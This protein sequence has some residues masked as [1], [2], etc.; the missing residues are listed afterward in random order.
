MK[1]IIVSAIVLMLFAGVAGTIQAIQA[2]SNGLFNKLYQPTHPVLTKKDIYHHAGIKTEL[3]SPTLQ[4]KTVSK[5]TRE[6]LLHPDGKNIQ[7]L[8]VLNKKSSKIKATE[9]INPENYH[10]V[11]NTPTPIKVVKPK[12]FK[13]EM[14]SRGAID[15]EYI[16]E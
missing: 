10:V 1:N 14:F 16:E 11:I 3:K 7:P 2:S 13:A 4:R 12:K 8:D 5:I 9:E 15:E 6:N